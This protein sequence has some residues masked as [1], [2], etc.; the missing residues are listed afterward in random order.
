MNK[1]ELIDKAVAQFDGKWPSR[2]DNNIYM[3]HRP[4][5]QETTYYP[6]YVS[7]WTGDD[8]VYWHI[9]EFQQRAREL[10]YLDEYFAVQGIDQ[11]KIKNT[12]ISDIAEQGWY[13]YTN[14]KSLRLPPVGVECETFWPLDS[15]PQWYHATVMYASGKNVVLNFKNAEEVSY[16]RQS[17]DSD[18]VLFRPLDYNR[19]AEMER[20][21]TIDHLYYKYPNEVDEGGMALLELLYDAGFLRM[22]EDK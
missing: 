5:I 15:E 8:Y 20:E 12:L 14:Q 21:N 19:K 6:F 2:I 4:E 18:G 3:S 11:Q 1:Q 16:K 17:L 9:E 22:P 10:G 7:S 13:D